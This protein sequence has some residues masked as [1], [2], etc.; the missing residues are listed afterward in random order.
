MAFPCSM[1]NSFSLRCKESLQLFGKATACIAN[2]FSP[3]PSFQTYSAPSGL[4]KS[5][6]P[7][8]GLRPLLLITPL[9]GLKH[10]TSS[11]IRKP[12]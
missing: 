5:F 9:R 8:K 7:Y 11:L 4:V 10:Q 1:E 6:A 3:G 12:L 2:T